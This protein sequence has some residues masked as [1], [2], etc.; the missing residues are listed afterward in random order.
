MQGAEKRNVLRNNS[1]VV[2]CYNQITYFQL[3]LHLCQFL[4]HYLFF[5]LLRVRD[6]INL[7]DLA[8]KCYLSD[9]NI[10]QV[11]N[12]KMFKFSPLFLK[13]LT[14]FKLIIMKRTKC[15]EIYDYD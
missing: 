5:S 9:E 10:S 14:L 4:Q 15:A 7:R 2:S 8:L 11:E 6:G 3:L 13:Y 12:H 1:R